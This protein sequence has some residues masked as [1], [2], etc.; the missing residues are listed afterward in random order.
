MEEKDYIELNTL[1]V[2][3]RV[4]CLKDMSVLDSEIFENTNNDN[5]MRINRK[6]R[7]RT[8]NMIRNIDNIRKQIPLKVENGIISNL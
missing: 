7:D 1:L 8:I 4:I 6:Q 2:K 5:I 3:L